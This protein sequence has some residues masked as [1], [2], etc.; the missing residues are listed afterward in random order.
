[1]PQEDTPP[2]RR[3]ESNVKKPEDEQTKSPADQAKERERE[4]EDSGAENA[5]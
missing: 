1:M 5:A 4:M 3:S 2:D